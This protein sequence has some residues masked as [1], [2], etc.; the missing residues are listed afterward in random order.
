MRQNIQPYLLYTCRPYGCPIECISFDVIIPETITYK[1]RH[2]EQ[3]NDANFEGKAAF[4]PNN[5]QNEHEQINS[6][7]EKY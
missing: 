7:T 5:I 3:M 1:E 4:S 2:S 6:K